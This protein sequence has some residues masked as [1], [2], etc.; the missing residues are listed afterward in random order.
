MKAS[1]PVIPK[2]FCSA[3]VSGIFAE[4]VYLHFDNIVSPFQTFFLLKK[5]EYDKLKSYKLFISN[6]DTKRITLRKTL[7]E[8]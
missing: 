1:S 8:Q 5:C 6:G 4:K 2:P 7:Y 3:R